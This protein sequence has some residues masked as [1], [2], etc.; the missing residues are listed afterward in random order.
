MKSSPVARL[1]T[2]FVV[3]ICQFT[4]VLAQDLAIPP[5]EFAWRRAAVLEQMPDS[6]VAIFHAA[7]S[8]TRSNDVEFEY[9]Q[10]NSLFYLTGITDHN[11]ALV[12]VKGGVDID[13]VKSSE[14]L[15][16]PRGNSRMASV[17]GK[18]ISMARAKNEL[19]FEVV[20]EY[21]NFGKLLGKFLTGRKELLYS[22]PVAFLYDTVSNQRYFI[23]QKAKKSFREKFNGLKVKS[24]DKILSGLRQIK[25]SAELRLLQKAID[26]TGEAHLVAMRAAKPE[27]Y[28]YQLEAI[29]EYVFKFNGAEYPAFPSIVGSGP[30]S[31]ILHYWKNR[32]QLDKDDLVVIDIG[33]EFQ[34]YSADVTRT[35]PANGKFSK[36]QKEIYETVLQAQK[37]AIAAVKPGVPLRDVH[38]VAKKVIREAGYAK[39]FNHGTSHYL[40]LDTHDV[41]GR[42]PLEPGMVITVEPGIY[43]PEGAEIDKEYWNIGVRIEDDV[44]VTEDGY[45]LL[46]HK[47]PREIA[48]IEM[49]MKEESKLFSILD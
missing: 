20:K 48:D 47:A 41:G 5:A 42:G 27:M 34:G 45:Q 7:Q 8:K 11:V 35:I 19:G 13:S 36:E 33:A 22:F 10:K 23:A 2:F 39:Y 1:L 24:P 40:G 4:L 16:I 15:F 32:R 37:E 12:L 26:I 28:E 14:V 29:I 38:K 17:L 44:L 46:S 49:V 30:N 31:T 6:S 21:D 3:T 25:S 43:I 9:R 18:T